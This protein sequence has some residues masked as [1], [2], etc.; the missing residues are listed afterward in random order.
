ME[1]NS[2]WLREKLRVEAGDGGKPWPWAACL[3]LQEASLSSPG[4]PFASG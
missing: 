4:L 2:A 1:E 3:E